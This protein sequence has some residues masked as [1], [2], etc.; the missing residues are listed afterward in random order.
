MGFIGVDH[1]ILPLS[2]QAA[3]AARGVESGPPRRNFV[4][5]YPLTASAFGQGRTSRGDEFR[6]V[7]SGQEPPQQDESLILPA[8][9][10]RIQVDQ[11]S[12][13]AE[14]PLGCAAD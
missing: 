9:P 6:L 13:H 14:G 1:K 7:P 12:P 4:D 11:Q 2:Q 3:Q 5:G 8:A 10:L